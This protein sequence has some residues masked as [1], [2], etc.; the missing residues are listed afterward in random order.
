[1]NVDEC[2]QLGYVIKNHGLKGEI[3]IFL[4]VDYPNE[5]KNLESV[6]VEIN[7]KLVP[8]FISKIQIRGDKAVV[9]LEDVETIEEAE[10]LRAKALYLPLKLLPQL[11]EN[12][13][14]YHQII[15]YT[16]IDKKNGKIGVIKDVNSSSKQDLFIVEN[17]DTKEILIPV[18]DDIIIKVD[19]QAEIIS[20]DLP[21][22]LL[23]VYL[24]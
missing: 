24:D 14:Y 17:A 5:Y 11:D 10:H 12:Q 1:M 3:N 22:G 13:F 16:V 20:V 19:H 4:D 8:F 21:D 2:F 18:I 9:R 23:D 15:N 6:F 7:D